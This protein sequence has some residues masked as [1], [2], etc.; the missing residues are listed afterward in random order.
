MYIQDQI[1]WAD[2]NGDTLSFYKALG[3]DMIHLE[4]R[5][6]VSTA[7]AGLGEDLRAGRDCTIQLEQ[8]RAIIEAHGLKLNNVGSLGS[9]G[10]DR[11]KRLR[12]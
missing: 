7:G 9:Q 8:A 12:P 2:L 6:G 1:R 4:L 5:G 10:V 11:K 3:V